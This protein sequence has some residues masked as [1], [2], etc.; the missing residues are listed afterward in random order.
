MG[1]GIMKRVNKITITRR[2]DET[3]DISYL[4]TFSDTPS[5][6]AIKHEGDSR[7][8]QYFNADNV[9]NMKEAQQNYDRAM[10]F[11]EGRVAQMGVTAE[12]EVAM[13]RDGGKTWKL[14][15]LTSGGL[16]GIESDSG[17]KYFKEVEDDQ[18][19]ELKETLEGY[20][21]TASQIKA[22]PIEHKE[23]Y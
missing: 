10:E 6:Y 15:E 3:G 8:Y 18:L 19:S 20:G 16:W 1:S 4:G 21:F 13:S 14:D 12:A 2:L 11:S 5:K 7:S 17:E 9:S 22:A 23:K